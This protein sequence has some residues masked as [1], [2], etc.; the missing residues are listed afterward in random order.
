LCTIAA[1]E[2]E[3][4]VT[5]QHG[6]DNSVETMTM[7]ALLMKLEQ[8]GFNAEVSEAEQGYGLEAGRC[9]VDQM[10]FPEISAVGELRVTMVG[11]TVCE[12]QKRMPQQGAFSATF[13]SGAKLEKCSSTDD[14]P[15]WA[16]AR[17]A[18]SPDVVAGFTEAVGCPAGAGLPLIWAVE[19][20][21]F[22]SGCVVGEIDCGCIGVA[23]SAHLLPIIAE[24]AM[25]M[26][27]VSR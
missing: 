16:R 8:D 25:A 17:A 6:L 24:T 12:V 4:H 27:S 3:Q 19:L 7:E 1:E 23:T 21:P 9:I 5:V 14:D 2:G 15:D 13:K 26:A 18:L 20:L 11:D 10:F 22:G